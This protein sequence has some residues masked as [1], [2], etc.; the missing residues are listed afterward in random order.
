MGHPR[1]GVEI[2]LIVSVSSH[3]SSSFGRGRA[4]SLECDINRNVDT[5]PQ[6]VVPGRARVDPS[7]KHEDFVK[8]EYRI[9]GL[10]DVASLKRSIRPLNLMNASATSGSKCAPHSIRPLLALG[11]HQPF[12]GI[13]KQR[14]A[15][16]R[17]DRSFPAPGLPMGAPCLFQL[18]NLKSQSSHLK[19]RHPISFN[20]DPN[21][22]ER[23]RQVVAPHRGQTGVPRGFPFGL[24]PPVPS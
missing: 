13:A 16:R 5:G 21:T 10:I 15:K 2:V 22:R 17:S 14:Y 1:Y 11:L 9:P 7:S 12:R 18:A 3:L 20:R 23:E 19:K 24:E 6:P 4:L 8:S